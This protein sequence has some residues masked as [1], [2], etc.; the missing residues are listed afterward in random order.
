MM[1]RACWNGVQVPTCLRNIYLVM[2]YPSTLS[3]FGV[4]AE[5]PQV[6]RALVHNKARNRMVWVL[7]FPTRPDPKRCHPT[8]RICRSLLKRFTRWT[9]DAEG[10]KVRFLL[11]LRFRTG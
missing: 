11:G 2:F 7:A 6:S 10:P 4:K 9:P 5:V 3:L 1:A 8:P